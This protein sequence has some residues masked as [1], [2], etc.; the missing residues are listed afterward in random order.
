MAS[1]AFACPPAK[2]WCSLL[3]SLAGDSIKTVSY[4][5]GYAV[6]VKLLSTIILLS[7]AACDNQ[8]SRQQISHTTDL[9]DTQIIKDIQARLDH[10]EKR[11]QLLNILN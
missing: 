9:S 7:L 8:A 1:T 4:G 5:Q 10:I 3:G 2:P 11:L 6:S